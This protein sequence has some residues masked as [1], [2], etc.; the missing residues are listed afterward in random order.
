MAQIQVLDKNIAE[1]IAAGE[2][3]EKP[4]SVIKEIVENSIDAGADHITVEI[5][6][7][8]ITFIRVTDNG[9]GIS[10]EDAPIAFLR[11]ATSKVRC[12][13]DLD[14]I[15]TMGFRGEA[16][17]SIAA[18]SRVELLTKCSYDKFGTHYSIEGGVEQ[19]FG[20]SGCPNGTTI[21]I[22]DLFYNTPAR[23]KFLKK[24][25]SEGNFVQSVVEKLA[26]SHPEISFRFIRDNKQII[27][28][29]GD[30]KSYSSIY[31]VFGKQ[32]SLTLTPV[33]YSQNGITV[34]GFISTPN[35]ARA[36]R[37]M[38]YFFINRRSVKN[39]T[40]MAALE[41]GYRNNIMTGKYPACVLNITMQ[42]CDLDVNVSP[43]KT[44]VRFA[45]EREVFTAVC[46]AT[47]NAILNATNFREIKIHEKKSEIP[48]TYSTSTTFTESPKTY[49]QTADEVKVIDYN[50]EKNE[51]EP[52]LA[53][54]KH[55]NSSR[56]VL[57]PIPPEK[58]YLQEKLEEPKIQSYD[59]NLYKYINKESLTNS[60]SDKPITM[61]DII[62]EEKTEGTLKF[63]GELF[64]T[65]ILC[66]YEDDLVLIDKHAA[67]ER[68]RFEKLKTEF[69][70]HSQLLAETVLCKLSAEEWNAL[71]E[72]NDIITDIGIEI[73]FYDGF[74]VEI[75]ALPALV[76]NKNPA[77]IIQSLADIF[78]RGNNNAL[79]EIFDD[80]LHTFACKSAIKAKDS[81]SEYE[82]ELL[83]RQ[84]WENKSLRYC[85]HGRPIITKISKYTL[86]KSF[87]RIQ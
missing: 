30:G 11:H 9:S 4:A 46:L 28:T 29:P 38:Q 60:L 2:V 66:E 23:L 3:I 53:T 76:I 6:N 50:E 70:S 79:G 39:T 68:I 61:P 34:S 78:I 7:G 17:A 71:H 14:S 8:G 64:S 58:L 31:A 48:I 51:E 40:C 15:H 59:E 35:F 45:N 73:I 52:I 77:E 24:D 10:R 19:D 57:A 81:T 16:L 74:K 87:G 75:T 55:L 54:L 86:E 41:E 72:N 26:L 33:D 36:S 18:V 67:H 20:E 82:I 5:K 44:E 80:I 83:A 65:Y 56:P 69:A 13:E 42:P 43:S 84:I 63:I 49:L 47:K 62:I 22:R 21:I 27:S 1:L 25:V 12:V 37:S 85:P 32:F